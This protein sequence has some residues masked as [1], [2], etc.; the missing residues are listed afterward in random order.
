PKQD[1]AAKFPQGWPMAY[2]TAARNGGIPGAST[3]SDGYS[4][5]FAGARA[6]PLDR[7]LYGYRAIGI[8]LAETTAAQWLGNTIGVSAVRGVILAESSDQF[9]YA[10]NA[11]TGQL[12]WRT[13]PVGST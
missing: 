9:I 1:V 8:K 5:K 3:T 2:Y 7:K 11:R 4:W 10:L 13:S 6:W 12:V